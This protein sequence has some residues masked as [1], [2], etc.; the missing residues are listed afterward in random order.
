MAGS[1]P[2]SNSIH[3]EAAEAPPDA[4]LVEIAGGCYVRAAAVEKGRK[5]RPASIGDRP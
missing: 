5:A 4:G 1:G 2:F 3:S